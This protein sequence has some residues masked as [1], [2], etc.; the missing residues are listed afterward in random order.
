MAYHYVEPEVAGELSPG[1]AMNTT[2]HPPVVSRLEYRFTD[3]L[4]DS[5]V[6]SF[7]CYLVTDELGEQIQQS[8]LGGAALDDVEAILSPEADE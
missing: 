6:E 3:W 5:I 8:G 7:P 4:G 1:T 2:V